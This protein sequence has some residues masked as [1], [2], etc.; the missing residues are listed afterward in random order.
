M[1]DENSSIIPM[2]SAQRIAA[3]CISN[4]ESIYEAL[5]KAEKWVKELK[6]KARDA[7]IARMPE[8]AAAYDLETDNYTVHTT[9]NKLKMKP[10]VIHAA[11][12]SLGLDP[13][14]VVY[15]LP[16]E[17]DVLPNG[18]DVLEMMFKQGIIPK[19]IYDTC[20]AAAGYTVTVKPKSARTLAEN[21]G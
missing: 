19:S 13:M 4:P 21:G 15:R 14:T 17:Y 11:L 5:V 6:E 16:V 2:E 9:K 3:L 8:D 1:G 18:R 10:M 12:V 7:V 20:F